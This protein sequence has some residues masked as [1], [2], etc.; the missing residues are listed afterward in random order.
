MDDAILGTSA[1][2]N[3]SRRVSGRNNKRFDPGYDPHGPVELT[4]FLRELSYLETEALRIYRA[5]EQEHGEYPPSPMKVPILNEWAETPGLYNARNVKEL[6]QDLFP[7]NRDIQFT[8][9]VKRINGH[10]ATRFS[11][12]ELIEAVK[13]LTRELTRETGNGR[14]VLPMEKDVDAACNAGTIVP[15]LGTPMPAAGTITYAFGAH[16]WAETMKII[17]PEQVASIRGQLVYFATLVDVI[18]DYQLAFM[19]FGGSIADPQGLIIT[20]A[21]IDEYGEISG[22]GYRRYQKVMQKHSD[23]GHPLTLNDIRRAAGLPSNKD[24]II[25]RGAMRWDKWDV[26]L[27]YIAAWNTIG[28]DKE[29]P[30]NDALR[31]LSRAQ[32]EIIN[33]FGQLDPDAARN[34]NIPGICVPTPPV[35]N[36]HFGSIHELLGYL[37]H[38]C[39]REIQLTQAR[40]RKMATDARKLKIDPERLCEAVRSELSPARRTRNATQNAARS[41]AVGR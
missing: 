38:H 33:E 6:F 8:T 5:Y 10:S 37:E 19:H 17:M 24:R 28:F 30:T 40:A 36:R 14:T 29:P 35:I 22:M 9:A 16:N 13:W 2:A 4:P 12:D 1:R 23:N 20:P 7:L 15:Q 11:R 31:D 27:G 3:G 32:T 18:R 39:S 26:M 25:R 41:K 21:M 34:R